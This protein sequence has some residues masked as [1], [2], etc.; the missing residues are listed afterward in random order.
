MDSFLQ[1]VFLRTVFADSFL[2]TVFLRTVFADNF[3]ADTI[4]HIACIK[5]NSS[6]SLDEN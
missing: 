5:S 2:Q 6:V 4:V 1:T 3:F